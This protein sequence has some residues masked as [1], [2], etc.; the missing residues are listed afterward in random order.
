[1]P[2]GRPIKSDCGSE[3]YGSAKFINH[4]LNPLAAKHASYIK[5]TEVKMLQFREPCFLFSMDVESLYTNIDTEM[6]MAAVRMAHYVWIIVF[7]S[8][9]QV[10]GTAMGKWF[11]PAYAI[12][13]I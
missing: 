1:M 2:S 7:C 12:I 4:F 9:L 8:F 6:G 5:N 3:S 11:S 13:Y 10:K